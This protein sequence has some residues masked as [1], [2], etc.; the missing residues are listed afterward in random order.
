MARRRA[1]GEG[2]IYRRKD[3]RYEGAVYLLTTSGNRKRIRVYGSSREEVHTK[4][5]E[6]KAKAQQGIP[7]PD[8]THKLGEY[9]DYWLENVVRPK[10][11]PKTYEH[12]ELIV[13]LYLKPG[14]GRFPLKRLSLPVLQTFLNQKLA[15][16]HS[17]RK[18]HMMRA[19]LSASLTRAEREELVS[20]NVAR[21]VALPTYHRPE[22]RPWSVEEA[23]Q[24]L[25][26]AR[27]DPLY[28]A[29]VLLL[30]YGLRRGEVLG[31]RWKD[32][33]F[34]R[35][36]IRIRQQLQR[37]G[38]EIHQSRVKTKAGE[39]DLPLLNIVRDVLATRHATQDAARDAAS[40]TWEGAAEDLLV[41]TTRNGS[42][43]E[44]RNFARSFDRVCTRHGIRTIRVHDVRHTT[45]T[46]LKDLRVPARDTQLIMGHSDIATTQAIYQH[47]TLETRRNALTQVEA[48]FLRTTNRE[49][50]RQEL[51]STLL[52]VDQLTSAISGWR[53]W[54]R[55]NDL[56]FQSSISASVAD[57]VTSVR[58]AARDRMRQ[59][60]CGAVAVKISRQI[61]LNIPHEEAPCVAG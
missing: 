15:D 53:G 13:R 9:L 35:S 36:E 24:F 28:P 2:S 44:P 37:V 20:R 19:V 26:A 10:W 18:V 51:P 58:S 5:T 30:L 50:C 27:P 54:I 42:P 14:L 60:L 11:R 12:Y 38:D 59:W 21:L 29:F 45:A 17:V 57:R 52:F 55:T 56:L 32:V 41:F 8:R 49:R 7:I 3:G 48:L 23:R 31:L 43:I 33:D 40:D 25:N 22:V 39:R 46:L 47:D 6:V 34:Q 61:S 16:G 1:N 4:L